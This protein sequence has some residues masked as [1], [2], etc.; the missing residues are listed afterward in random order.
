[1]PDLRAP[2]AGGL[3]SVLFEALRRPRPAAL[4]LGPLRDPGRRRRGRLR[5][6]AISGRR[7]TAPDRLLYH[8]AGRLPRDRPPLDRDCRRPYRRPPSAE[9]PASPRLGPG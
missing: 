8:D 6:L 1:M 7:L 2:G 3:P 4:A 9:P 5:S